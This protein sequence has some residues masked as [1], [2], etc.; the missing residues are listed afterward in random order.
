MRGGTGGRTAVTPARAV[1][2]EFLKRPVRKD[3]NANTPHVEVPFKDS[4]PDI[5]QN[6]HHFSDAGSL[7]FLQLTQVE[8]VDAKLRRHQLV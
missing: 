6:R 4:L 2:D 7:Q 8:V 1:E 3:K 5:E